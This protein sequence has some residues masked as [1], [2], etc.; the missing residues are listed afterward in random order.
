MRHPRIIIASITLAAAAAVGGG[1]TAAAA[2]TSHASSPPAPAQQAAATVRTAQ[3]PVGGKTETILVTSAGL[4]LY[5]Y[6]NDTA[7]KSA[8]T[9]GGAVPWS[10]LT[11]RTTGRPRVA[12][13]P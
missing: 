1:I 3:A 4:P 5:Y 12:R 9:G 8:L 10:P 7:A 13:T 2:T 6:L 11:S